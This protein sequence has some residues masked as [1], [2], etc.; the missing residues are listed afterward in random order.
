MGSR[1]IRLILIALAFLM[2]SPVK[3]ADWPQ[4][5]GPE[6][7][8]IASDVA[9]ADRWS[10]PPARLWSKEIG[11]GH[12]SPV[13]LGDRVFTHTRQGDDEVL[14][15]FD[16]SNGEIIWQSRY[17]APYKM[18]SA[19]TGHGKGPKST[20]V[21][22]RGKLVT[23]GISGILSC[24]NLE[25]GETAWRHDFSGVFETTSPL[26]GTAMSPIAVGDRVIAH[27]GGN[28]H[29]ALRAYSLDSGELIWSWD[30][31]GP[32]YASP[33]LAKLGGV[34]Q[35]VTQ[36]QEKI[37]GVSLAD[38]SELWQIPFS[39]AYVQNIVTPIVFGDLLVFSGLQ[40][41]TFA[42]RLKEA[43]GRWST[44]EVWNN[45]AV[46]S[47]MSSP[48]LEGNSL[49]GFSHYK[50]GQL[51]C[52]DARS[53]ETLWTGP[54]RQG[55]SAALILSKQL[56]FVLDTDAEFLV[57]QNSSEGL[58]PVAEHTIADSP[59]WAHPVVL[60]SRVLI[61]DVRNLTLWDFSGR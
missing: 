9:G 16:L 46:S 45:S 60:G 19:A 42:L 40:K 22:H 44:E 34:E 32:G 35:I 1:K 25:S 27:V 53:G 30:G 7:N 50:K 41:G 18:N 49:F 4:W 14:S 21:I 24:S 47:Y 5:R 48:V 33:V 36:S 38:G 39:T 52:L 23:L 54:G 55:E 28:D 2:H 56:L 29:G 10:D 6:R 59:T 11:S 43:N 51:F 13:V 8:G 17:P 20:P 12:S 15:C 61:K 37:I 57:Y 31:D 58:R 3:P 26:Y